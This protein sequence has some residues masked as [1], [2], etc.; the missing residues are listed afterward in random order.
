MSSIKL[1]IGDSRL[2][3]KSIPDNS[4]DLLFTDPPYNLAK[5]STG[6]IAFP[7][8]KE[9]NNDLAGWD[10][11]DFA[12]NDWADDF[13]RVMKPTANLLIFTSYNLLGKWHE[14][15][16]HRFDTFQ[17]AVWHKT[18]PIPKFHRNGFLNSCELIII[19][20]N[21]GHTWNFSKQNEMHNFFE[22]PIC[23]GNERLK[24][25][26]HPTQKPLKLLR[27]LVKIASNKGDVIY[28]PFMGVGSMGVAAKEMRRKF[29]GSELD[30]LY[31]DAA[32]KRIKSTTVL[33]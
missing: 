32:K 3:V 30:A 16:D 15:L 26:V 23:M 27:H 19:C 2:L 18:N 29:I 14:A 5:Y 25:P 9:I 28:D 17:F 11:E 6:N 4:I 8:R 7:W 20:Y 1:S 33:E 31:F 10:L 13:I 21:K 12:P 22:Y 24:S